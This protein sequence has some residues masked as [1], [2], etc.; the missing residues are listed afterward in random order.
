MSHYALSEGSRRLDW[1]L[2]NRAGAGEKIV[3]VT[4]KEGK[5]TVGVRDH[6]H[7]HLLQWETDE[8]SR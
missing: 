7:T 6:H 3:E 4:R 2:D 1:R 5:Y 8:E